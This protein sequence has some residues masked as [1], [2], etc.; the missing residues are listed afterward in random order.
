[1]WMA[2]ILRLPAF[3]RRSSRMPIAPTRSPSP[4]RRSTYQTIL[5]YNTNHD[6]TSL[7]NPRGYTRTFGY[8]TDNSL[9]WQKDPALNQTSYAYT[10]TTCTV[11]DPNG[12]NTIYTYDTSGRNTQI[13][14]P[15]LYHQDYT[16]D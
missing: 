6:V 11:T 14:D 8:N 7:Q 13:K 16:W 12:N 5:G 4:T 1:M 9:A 10:S 3:T 2:A 15:L